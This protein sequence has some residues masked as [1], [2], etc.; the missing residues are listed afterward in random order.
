MN[1]L[2][3][4]LSASLLSAL[5][6]LLS[7]FCYLLSALTWFCVRIVY[8][9]A[10]T[11]CLFFFVSKGTES[12]EQRAESREQRAESRE[13]RAESREQRAHLALN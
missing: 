13:Q 5:C 9:L 10:Y 11:T 12:R 8:A 3:S 2:C 7:A 6:S 1:A 4:L